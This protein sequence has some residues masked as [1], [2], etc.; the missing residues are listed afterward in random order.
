MALR[1]QTVDTAAPPGTAQTAGDQS[2][3][4]TNALPALQ[5]SLW[6]K[7]GTTVTAVRFAGVTFDEKNAIVSELKQKVGEPLDPDKVRADMR[8]LFA[9]GLY[10]NISVSVVPDGEWCGAGVFG[11]AAIFCGAGDD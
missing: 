7:A 11:A 6:S 9:S 4:V 2:A 8:R 5:T 1:A 3:Q 10:V